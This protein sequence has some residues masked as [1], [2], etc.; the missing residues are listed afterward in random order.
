MFDKSDF[1]CKTNP[2]F[3]HFSPENEDFTKKQTQFKP[4]S[5]PNK[6]NNELKIR[7]QIQTNP[8]QTQANPISRAILL[9]A[10]LIFF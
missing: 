4:N 3:P 8:I 1:F 6:H 9:G 5:K 10:L 7:G 2:I